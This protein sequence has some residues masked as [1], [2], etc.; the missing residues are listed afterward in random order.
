MVYML[1]FGVYMDGKC[2][3]ILHTWI[4]WVM[5]DLLHATV[6]LFDTLLSNWGT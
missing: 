6:I 2:Y 3:H 5:F 4:L 1:T